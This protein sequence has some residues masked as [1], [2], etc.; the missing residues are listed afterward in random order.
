MAITLAGNHTKWPTY[1]I[2]MCKN[3]VTLERVS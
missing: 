2:E 3:T 1:S